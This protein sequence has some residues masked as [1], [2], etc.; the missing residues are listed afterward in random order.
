MGVLHRQRNTLPNSSA[1]FTA[2]TPASAAAAAA[3]PP[4]PYSS[5]SKASPLEQLDKM[6]LAIL[7]LVARLERHG[8]H[9]ATGLFLNAQHK[10]RARVSRSSQVELSDVEPLIAHTADATEAHCVLNAAAGQLSQSTRRIP[11]ICASGASARRQ[12]R[13]RRRRRHTRGGRGRAAVRVGARLRIAGRQGEH[14]RA[15]AAQATQCEHVAT[16]REHCLLQR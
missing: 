4:P 1:T 16:A 10:V 13:G 15:D 3:A 5:V 6:E 8:S 12:S 9:S 11:R 7:T 2:K 14:R